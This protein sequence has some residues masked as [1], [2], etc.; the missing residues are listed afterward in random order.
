MANI[1]G[2]S[3][4]GYVAA[5]I[6]QRQKAHGSGVDSSNPRT[7]EYYSYL[8]SKTAWVKLAS[9]ITIKPERIGNGGKDK[10]INDGYAWTELAKNYILFSGTSRLKD[11][12]L[13]PRGTSN[14]KNN[15]WD[16]YDGAYNVNANLNDNNATGEFGLVPMPG[17][18][19][20]EVK[21]LNRGSIKKATVNLK[22][23]SPE[24][25][26]IINLLYLRI[27][28]TMLL[29]WGWAPYL[30]NNGELVQDY[31]TLIENEFFD[32][33]NNNAS[34]LK[35][36][37][38]INGYRAAKNGNYDG[39]L[40]K[41]VN[42][43]WTFSQD[44]SYDIQLSLIS[45]GDVVESLKTNITPSYTMFKFI[46]VAYALYNNATG[47]D[48]AVTPTPIDNIIS[49][50]L[51]L[52]KLIIDKENNPA[53]GVD[54]S[55]IYVPDSCEVYSLINTN[56]INLAGWWVTPPPGYLF[57]LSEP[58]YDK[59]ECFTTEADA[60]AWVRSTN[61][62]I[63]STYPR[64]GG[65]DG[66]DNHDVL[67]DPSVKNA[68]TISNRGTNMI[69]ISTICWEAEVKSTP[70]P[71]P[72]PGRAKEDVIYL[73][74]NNEEGD[75]TELNDDGFY[76]RFGHLLQYVNDN[77][78][79]K[80]EGTL[81]PIFNI[82]YGQWGN[83]MYVFPYQI[84]LDPRVCVVNGGELV[85][86]KDYFPTL[87]KWKDTTYG[88]GYPMNIY[89]SHNQINKSI[90]GNLDEEGNLAIFSFI[91]DICTEL[92]KALGGVN[93]LEVILDEEQN[94]LK[95][96]DSSYNPYLK[97]NDYEL[98]LYGYNGTTSNFVH[99]F[100]L[101]TEITNEFA[102][103][104]T[105]GSTAGG[106]VKGTENT[107]F[108]K[109]NKG[110]IDRFKEK[111]VPGDKLSRE[112]SGSVA[113]PNEMYVDKIWFGDVS[114]FGY[115][116]FN[117]EDWTLSNSSL[118]LSNDVIEQNLS[119]GTEFYKYCQ[120]EIQTNYNELHASSTTGFI[121]ISLGIT[122]EGLSGIKIYNAL[123][124]DTRFLPADYP[125]ALKFIIKGVNHSV[126]DGNWNT[127]IETIVIAQNE[128]DQAI[129]PIRITP[130]PLPPPGGRL[131]PLPPPILF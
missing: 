37:K 109:W 125:N 67:H 120:S 4:H 81:D 62:G 96:I 57:H 103:M 2:E 44:G 63:Y 35:F 116:L 94:I 119:I 10:E 45:L 47:T 23:Y 73:N 31:T 106:Y 32:P 115:T 123:N 113:E 64:I 69:L 105:I 87:L 9:G 5:Q 26:Q 40:C 95:I 68:Y 52:Q 74:Y 104:A 108:S 21:C 30:D 58:F 48:S 22:C 65:S 111:L 93:N 53:T 112:V 72:L 46:N 56:R 41:V 17:I 33:K 55:I 11:G 83:F 18:I 3:L 70:D 127:N 24:Q 71:I 89:V 88:H 84:S 82:D 90:D 101:K 34:H 15:I 6:N 107:M 8:N 118:G 78:I 49:A 98:E 117:I 92:N 100:E 76:M 13:E 59:S 91:Q 28:Y 38:K 43:N 85:S 54:R 16:F 61:G 110:L 129:P 128:T 42:F 75:V 50:Y 122:M 12:K 77:V 126:K 114:A 124:V 99:D 97:K 25:F 79:P 131:P 7:A 19:D 121:P 39:L 66:G 20:M 51:F 80:I 27:G 86:G 130:T 1:I 102:T 36:L 14:G 29:E 60:E